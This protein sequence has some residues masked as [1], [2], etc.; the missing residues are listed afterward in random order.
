MIYIII[1]SLLL[2]ILFFSVQ[3]GKR[4][5]A[6]EKFS[7]VIED[8]KEQQISK[9]E[10]NGL[11]SGYIGPFFIPSGTS[12]SSEELLDYLNNDETTEGKKPEVKDS[13]KKDT[14]K[15]TVYKELNREK[16]DNE[17][18]Y[19]NP[20]QVLET[21]EQIK[22]DFIPDDYDVIKDPEI[23]SLAEE[24]ARMQAEMEKEKDISYSEEVWNVT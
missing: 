6:P 3:N 17:V 18:L 9:E 8:D 5:K 12:M 11:K 7:G 19:P 22:E 10:D 24:E 4:E 20:R 14:N 23:N 16:E 15:K 21:E 1:V 2:V 13:Y